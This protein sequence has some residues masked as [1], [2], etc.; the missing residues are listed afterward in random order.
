MKTLLVICNGPSLGE[1]DFDWFAKVDTIGMNGAYRKYPDLG[2][3]PK[4]F[5]CFDYKVTDHHASAWKAM[6]ED[7]NVPIEQYFFTKHI[8]NSPKLK[9][10]QLHGGTGCFSDRFETFGCGGNTGVNAC[11]VG[12][13]LGYKRILII[14]ADCNYTDDIDGSKRVGNTTTMVIERMPETNPNYFWQDYQLPGDVYNI[15]RA[16]EFHAPAWNAFSR[17]AE[18]K[19]IDVAMCTSSTLTCFRKSSLPAELDL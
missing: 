14:G 1:V 18:Q 7:S 8:S 11:Q 3:Y 16:Q 4:Y 6:I 10:L 13:C 12:V 15:P 19:K 5:C 2:W 17:F 9:V